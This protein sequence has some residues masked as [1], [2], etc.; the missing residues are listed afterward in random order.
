MALPAT[1]EWDVRTGGSDTNGGGFDPSVASPGTDYSQ[2]DAAQVAYTDLVIGASNTLTSVGTP[3]TSAHVGNNI[4]ITGGTGFTTG[5]YNIRSV[6]AAVAT[7]DRSPGTNG[8]IGGTGNL[9]GGLLT[10]GVAVGS[11]TILAGHVVHI[12]NGT[13]TITSAITPAVDGAAGTPI[14]VRGYNATHNDD[15]TP[16]VITCATNSINIF[17]ISGRDFMIF[18]NIKLT[19]TAGTRGNGFNVPSAVATSIQLRKIIADGC[20]RGVYGDNVTPFFCY[21]ILRSCEIKNSTIAGIQ[22]P[23]SMQYCYIHDNTGDGYGQLNGGAT[24]GNAV[25]SHCI[26][27]TNTGDGIDVNSPGVSVDSC[28]FYANGGDGIKCSGQE[29]I[30]NCIFSSNTGYG[31]NAST[32]S[33]A[34][35]VNSNRNA[36]YSNTAGA[37]NNVTAG[38]NDVTLTGIPFTDAPNGDFTLNNTSGAGA[39]CRGTGAPGTIYGTTGVGYKDIGAL[40]HQDSGGGGSATLA[41]GFVG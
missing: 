8:S 21:A 3:F 36:F 11:S 14:L 1:L 37:R 18:D 15:G 26:F 9:G 19:H 23:V 17:D 10:V 20:A 33:K 38:A 31:I 5:W 25:I 28:S 2:Q 22:A 29:L 35:G 39:N 30:F 24:P 41:T 40:Q 16:P 12:R 32:V 6:A 34:K 27:D 13:Y 4:R 7:M